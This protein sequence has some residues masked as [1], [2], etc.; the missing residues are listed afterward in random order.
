M[1]YSEKDG[2]A[3]ENGAPA[4]E[5][6]GMGRFDGNSDAPSSP[7]SAPSFRPTE[8]EPYVEADFD[9]IG[10]H[11]VQ[12][13][14]K[15]GRP[16]GKAPRKG[17]RDSDP[18]TVEEAAAHMASGCNVGVRLRRCH[19][20][21]DVDPRNFDEG[22]DPL[23]RL[24]AVLN[25]DWTDFPIVVTGS[26]GKHIYMR[27]PDDV[28]VVNDLPAYPG[29][30]FKSFGRQVVAA[31]SLHPG[32]GMPY[33][34]DDD[35]L[36]VP[37]RSCPHAPANLIEAL[38]RPETSATAEPG[39]YAGADLAKM[40]T[41][42]NVTDY[43]EHDRWLELMMACHHATGGRGRE[44]FIGW[45]VGD[46]AYRDHAEVIGRRWDGLKADIG[47]RQV[48]VR[49]LIKALADAG[50]TDVIPRS[51]AEDDFA[52][53]LPGD[54]DLAN[55]PAANVRAKPG[56][57]GVAD[58]WVYVIDAEMFIRR[59]D[60]KKWKKEQ[61][62]ARYAGLREGDIVNAVFKGQFPV[63]KFEALEY[64]PCE[65]EFPGGE[66]GRRYNI[67]RPSGIEAKPGDVQPFL[68]HMVYLF[69]D[70]AERGHALDYL[71]MLVQRPD[72]KVNFALLVKG[73]QGTGKSWI[74]RL[75]TKII[76]QRNVVLPSNSEVMS[77]WTA[78]TEGAQLGIVEELM[79]PGRFDMANRLKP[80]ITEPYLRIES[81]GCSLYSIPNKL[82]LLAFTNHDDAVPIERGDRRWLVLFSDAKPL[83]EAY[84]ERLFDFLDGDGPAAVK[85]W[86][87]ERRIGLN[88]KGLAPKTVG[89]D[90]MRRLSM[91]DAEQYLTELLEEG[92]APFDFPLV[93]FEEVLA[94]VPADVARRTS[95][96]RNKVT[97]WITG[98]AAAVKHE[99]YKK[100]DGSG[101]QNCHLWSTRDHGHWSEIG[102]AARIDAYLAY[103]KSDNRFAE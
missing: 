100:Q 29:V 98:E 43:S 20:V 86:L 84:Y 39:E 32:T 75:M 68:D 16:L 46:P 71:A 21:V 40:L 67:W 63:R 1:S 41:G 47:R 48:T 55:I 62:K 44:E 49:T 35:L 69:G 94:A 52:D 30:E 8:L 33:L 56:R 50:R 25:I 99:R 19:L 27:K 36:A 102:A 53:D 73:G 10:L 15:R 82:N 70:E 72:Q 28:E 96:L 95:G 14:D 81:K 83:D 54:A 12:A 2:R 38:R 79:A 6:F 26:G 31:G 37:L 65:P 23:G 88:P 34:W 24:S 93:R 61:W 45:S 4:G 90:Q 5:G 51:S 97:K 9:L 77:Q 64:L 11:A 89:K 58:E 66:N 78:W 80:I 7:P 103:R 91:G 3:G 17:W 87:M 74:G 18:M 101:R 13:L 85:N 92:S 22:D 76:G 60:G 42:L 59:S 57:C